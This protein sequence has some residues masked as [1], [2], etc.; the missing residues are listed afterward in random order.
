MSLKF[1]S[2]RELLLKTKQFIQSERE[3]LREVER[4][5]LSRA[6]LTGNDEVVV[7]VYWYFGVFG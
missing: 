5:H 7:G 4:R 3:L 2:D 1:L 6:A